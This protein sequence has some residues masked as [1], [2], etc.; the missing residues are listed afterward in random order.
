GSLRFRVN[1][2]HHQCADRV[3]DGFRVTARADDGIVEAM[4]HEHLPY[5]VCVQFHPELLTDRPEFLRLFQLH[6]QACLDGRA[7]R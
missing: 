2:Y 7:S 1:S 5:M 6:V 4:E 3:A